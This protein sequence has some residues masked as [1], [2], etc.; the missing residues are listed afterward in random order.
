MPDLITLAEHRIRGSRPA[1]HEPADR[2]RHAAFRAAYHA[3]LADDSTMER[4]ALAF[5]VKAS[6]E[7]AW[8]RAGRGAR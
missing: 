5:A 3:A 4:T 2:W 6:R 1:L 7:L 8:A